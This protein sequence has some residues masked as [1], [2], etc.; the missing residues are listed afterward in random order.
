MGSAFYQLCPR[1]SGTLTPT[2][3]TAIRLW[4]TFTF[5]FHVFVGNSKIYHPMGCGQAN[6]LL[7]EASRPK[8]IVDGFIH[9]TEDNISVSLLYAWKLSIYI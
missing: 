2:A 9:S 8:E 5:L 7:S 4:E 3:P 1:Y 6:A